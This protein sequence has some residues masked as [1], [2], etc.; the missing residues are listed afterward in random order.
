MLATFDLML[1]LG[2]AVCKDD[3]T[4][5]GHFVLLAHLVHLLVQDVVFEFDEGT[6]R[7]ARAFLDGSARGGGG[8]GAVGGRRALGLRL[9]HCGRHA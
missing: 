4:G 9:G 7:H 3:E 1:V 2:N 8:F 6:A 5:V